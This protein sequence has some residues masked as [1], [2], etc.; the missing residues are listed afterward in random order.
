MIASAASA[1]LGIDFGTEYIKAALVK[2]GIPLEIVLTKDSKRKEAATVAFKPLRHAKPDDFPERLYGS[3]AVAL[4]ARF[5]ADVYPNLK[6]LLAELASSSALV[7]GYDQR[8][9]DLTL[10]PTEHRGTVAFKSKAF[11]DTSDPFTVEELLAMQLQNV[12]GN[13]ESLAGKGSS[14]R[15]IVITVP[16]FYTISERRA[17]ELAADLAG[18]K[19]LAL[20]TDGLAVGLNYATSRTFPSISDGAKAEQHLVFD[21]GAGSTS[22]TVLQ[23]QGRTVKDVGR[24]NKT[25]QEVNVLGTGWDRTLGGDALNQIVVDQ[26]LE[27]FLDTPTA[28]KQ[29]LEPKSVVT[30]G[31]AMAKLWKEAERLR[32][33]LSANSETAAS[34]EGLYE[35]L[36]FR[37]KLSRAEFEKL[38]SAFATRVEGPIVRALESAKLS[39]TDLDSIILHGGA[40][41]TPF[42]QRE[43]ERL[44]GDSAKVRNN[45][46]ADEAAVFG[47]AFKGASLSPSFRVKEIRTGD[48][49]SHTLVLDKDGDGQSRQ[50]RLFHPTSAVGAVKHVPFGKVD[51]FS[52]SLHQVSP[53]GDQA[54]QIQTPVFK[55]TTR[56]LTASVAQL[57][58]N[59]GCSADNIS[60]KFALRISSVDGRPEVLKGTVSCDVEGEK[61]GGVVDDVKGFFGF[62]SGSKKEDQDPLAEDAESVLQPSSSTEATTVSATT[63]P[64][65]SGS[66]AEASAEAVKEKKPKKRTETIHIEYVKEDLGLPTFAKADLK[67]MKE[68]LAA[69]DASDSTRLHREEALNVLEAF[70]YKTRDFLEDE[71]IEEVSTASER[72]SLKDKVSATSD[73]LYG[74]GAEADRTA[75]RGRLK[76]LKDIVSPI[77]KR[78]EELEKR[79]QRISSLKGALKQTEVLLD[80][81]RQQVEASESAAA[82]ESSS[83]DVAASESKASSTGDG[84]EDLEHDPSSTSTT[85]EVPASTPAIPLYTRDDVEAI[86]SIHSSISTWLAEK[87]AQQAKLGPIDEPA[88]LLSDLEVRARQLNEVV[89][90]LA[91]KKV[92][93]L[94]K[95]KATKAKPKSKKTKAGKSKSASSTTAAADGES[96][97][98]GTKIP[99][100]LDDIDSLSEAELQERLNRAMEDVAKIRDGEKSKKH[101]E[102]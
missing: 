28:K 21:M 50:Q 94:P 40:S 76:E 81:V 66:S 27:Q 101:D 23:F 59:F 11:L 83:V 24:F 67:R 34:F 88:L 56:N 16:A 92:K 58:E 33:V 25:V 41:R 46:N 12:R 54:S 49:S 5:P 95:S 48:I 1:V 3:D 15:D 63:V 39:I 6:P 74:D 14:I 45:V 61:K 8:L 18:L 89:V 102:L 7:A 35:E 51:D 57:S 90:G 93:V 44:A 72:S 73:W 75:L 38:T 80:M 9:P 91:N 37:Y 13:A 17:I 53:E 30:H 47:A 77:E 52:F 2:P 42:V 84:F 100:D 19:V 96:A 55:L 98:P 87:E 62:G 69:F 26:M 97:T 71:S 60:T 36:D 65:Q 99:L 86:E 10:V 64:D 70:T 22:A 31:R 29:G 43:L 32:Q 20:L 79:P 68:R 85:S 4:A 82:A 78:I